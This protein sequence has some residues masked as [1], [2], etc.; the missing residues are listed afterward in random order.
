MKPAGG[1]VGVGRL[2]PGP[3]SA[4]EPEEGRERAHGGAMSQAKLSSIVPP[5]RGAPF[6]ASY[7]R[8]QACTDRQSCVR[9]AAPLDTERTTHAAVEEFDDPIRR[10]LWVRND[11]LDVS[12]RS[13]ERSKLLRVDRA[14]RIRDRE[15][16]RAL[17]IQ[18]QW[19][20]TRAQRKDEPGSFPDRSDERGP[21][22]E[23]ESSVR[24]SGRGE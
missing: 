24:Q 8:S 22:L 3:K 19:R 12:M 14:S 1:A 20:A 17:R 23:E 15:S 2:R 9:A 11:R 18:R 6:N 7:A 10:L 5:A 16:E 4:S 13:K 21:S